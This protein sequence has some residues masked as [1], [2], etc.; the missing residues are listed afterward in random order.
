MMN[1]ERNSLLC[2][3]SRILRGRCL[4]MLWYATNFDSHSAGRPFLYNTCD[5]LWK[6][7]STAVGCGTGLIVNCH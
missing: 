1:R 2:H 7:L 4:G 6:S 5:L 3:H